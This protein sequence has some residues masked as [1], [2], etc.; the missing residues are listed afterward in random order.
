MDIIQR[1]GK[2]VR[3]FRKRKGFTQA[4]LAEEA[5]LSPFFIGQMERGVSAPSIMSLQRIA[6][7]LGVTLAKLFEESEEF[8]QP[9]DEKSQAIEHLIATL[10]NWESKDIKL[11]TRFITKLCFTSS[12]GTKD[13]RLLARLIGIARK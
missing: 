3:F 7:A 4:K 5:N 10:Q 12:L 8:S 6:D 1:L 13:I 9:V 2:R 11:L